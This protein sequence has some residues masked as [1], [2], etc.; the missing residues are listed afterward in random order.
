MDTDIRL[1]TITTRCPLCN[2]KKLLWDRRATF[3][4]HCTSCKS[5]WRAGTAE[6]VQFAAGIIEE[7][8]ATQDEW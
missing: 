5:E 2:E 7:Y 8:E 1:E 6:D 4:I 3:R